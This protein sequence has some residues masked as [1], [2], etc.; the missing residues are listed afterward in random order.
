MLLLLLAAPFIEPIM[1]HAIIT[2]ASFVFFVVVVVAVAI[3]VV[4]LMRCAQ[5]QHTPFERHGSDNSTRFDSIRC[6][7]SRNE[8]LA[9]GLV[10]YYFGLFALCCVEF[11]TRAV[12]C[13]GLRYDRDT[14]R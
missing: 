4:C 3:L 7:A 11:G 5:H 12:N 6:D 14:I 8:L 9:S 10:D 2:V 13:S 1:T